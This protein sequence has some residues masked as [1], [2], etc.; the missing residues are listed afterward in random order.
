MFEKLTVTSMAQAMADRAGQRLG[1]IAK[2][3]ANADTPG[4]KALDLPDFAASYS[5]AAIPMRATRAGHLAG[6]AATPWGNPEPTPQRNGQST[7]PNGNSVS[8]EQE[9]VKAA[10]VRQD[11]EM[12]LA[13][14][15]NTSDIIRAA[16]GRSR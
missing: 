8:I 7:A 1:L 11:H 6:M 4:Y 3:I 10:S 13:I 5:A 16:L 9:M 2:N 15:R 12:A 14:Y